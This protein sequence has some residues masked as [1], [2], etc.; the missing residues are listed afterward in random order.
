VATSTLPTKIDVTGHGDDAAIAALT[1]NIHAL[2]TS[3][4]SFAAEFAKAGG[5]S[6]AVLDASVSK[7]T[8]K[9][10]E[11]V[12]A[13][14]HLGGQPP[15]SGASAGAGQ[16]SLAEVATA[17]HNIGDTLGKIQTAVE[18]TNPRRNIRGQEGA[19]R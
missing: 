2:N 10:N 4:S 12:L 15:A 19:Q 16:S 13:I 6:P 1:Q 11:A 3:I 18:G 8:E 17:L 9:L 5:I 14:K 7:I